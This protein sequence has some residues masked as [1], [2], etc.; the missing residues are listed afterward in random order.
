MM[1]AFCSLPT[2]ERVLTERIR[3]GF[4]LA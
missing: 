4:E 2:K 1:A 3:P